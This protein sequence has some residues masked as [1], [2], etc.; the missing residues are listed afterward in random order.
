MVVPIFQEKMVDELDKIQKAFE[1][2]ILKSRKANERSASVTLTVAGLALQK[3]SVH[4]LACSLLFMARTT[5]ELDEAVDII[6]N[7]TEAFKIDPSLI[8]TILF[9]GVLGCFS[10]PIIGPIIG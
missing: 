9:S 3:A 2:V 10:I 8:E 4:R 1:A 6:L 5:H 7:K